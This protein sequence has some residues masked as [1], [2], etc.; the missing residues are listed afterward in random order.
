[1]KTQCTVQLIGY[2]GQD[3]VTKIVTNG[4]LLVRLRLATDYYRRRNDGSLIQKV[5]WHNIHAWDRL[6]E[7]IPGNYIKGSHVLVQGEIVYRT[8]VDEHGY[9][10]YITEIRADKMLNLDR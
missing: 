6:A 10:H 7:K 2:L 3:P 8:Y 1:M 5:N 9:K 4:S